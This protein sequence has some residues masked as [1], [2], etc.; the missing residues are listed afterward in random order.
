[1]AFCKKYINFGTQSPAG[2]FFLSFVVFLLFFV[3]L[4][5]W[6]SSGISIKTFKKEEDLF[7]KQLLQKSLHFWRFHTGRQ[8]FFVVKT[9]KSTLFSYRSFPKTQTRISHKLI[10]HWQSHT[11]TLL[12][13]SKPIKNSC[14][15]PQKNNFFE[16][17][18]W[19]A[20]GTTA[21][22]V[23]GYFFQFQIIGKIPKINNFS[24]MRKVQKKL[25][26]EKFSVRKISMFMT[27]VEKNQFFFDECPDFESGLVNDLSYFSVGFWNP[28]SDPCHC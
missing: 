25:G 28:R 13:R 11:N 1:M 8:L 14:E 15:F 24:S 16:R 4:K 20:I 22:G 17:A 5:Q 2:G 7:F 12:F 26:V 18:L 10:L 23:S 21:S 9:R 6:T 3:F 19:R 27:S